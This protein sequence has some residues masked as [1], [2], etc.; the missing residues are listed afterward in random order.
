MAFGFLTRLPVPHAELR[1]GD[2]GRARGWFPLV[3]VVVAGIGTLTR[4][5]VGLVLPNTVAVAAGVL[6]M[7]VVTG[8]FHEDGL[9][10]AVDGIWGGTTPQRRLEIMHDSRLGTYG[11]LALVGSVLLRVAILTPLES[12][13]FLAATLVGHVAGRFAILP[14]SAL[15]PPFPDSSATLLGERTTVTG[16]LVATGTVVGV[17]VATLGVDAWAPVLAG[18]G[19]LVLCAQIV[20]SKLGGLTGDVLGASNQVVHLSSMGAAAAVLT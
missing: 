5:S 8:A 3:G 2:I 1:A 14:L 18:L 12:R 19:S 20:R 9:A 15:L 13:E 7:I 17:V 16:W 4:W 10:D 6:A 11:T